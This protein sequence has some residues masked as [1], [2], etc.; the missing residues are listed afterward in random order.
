MPKTD[1]AE[2]RRFLNPLTARQKDALTGYMEAFVSKN[3]RGQM[4]AVLEKRTRRVV[5]VVENVYQPH[6]AGAIV[7]T[8]DC[9]GF[10]EL[11]VVERSYDF[12]I[13]A[14]VT[15]G[16]C[17]WISLHKHA[18]AEGNLA[19]VLNQ[20]KSEG[21][22]IAATSLREGCIELEDLALSKPLALCF[23]TEEKGLSEEA[24][25]LADVRVG[26]PSYG[27]TQ[28]YN[29]SVSAALCMSSIRRR[30]ESGEV[31]WQLSESEKAD[32]YLTWLMQTTNR[33]VDIARNALER[34]AGGTSV[35]RWR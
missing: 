11:H 5:I 17:K 26:I 22:T 7:R 23:G 16:A 20:L 31:D 28:S 25:E 18:A 32:L 27:F 33:G 12:N 35:I 21:F 8:C 10:Q 13:S 4:H 34:I 15:M 24:H 9:F 14:D 6:N 3:K 2:I 1:P 19:R 29:V 30:M